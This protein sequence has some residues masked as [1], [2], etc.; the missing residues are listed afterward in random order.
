MAY[1]L[2]WT[3][4]GSANKPCLWAYK[5]IQIWRVKTV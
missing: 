1:P 2:I 3:A 4:S 5:M